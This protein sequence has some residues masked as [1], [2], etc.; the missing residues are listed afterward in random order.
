M[1]SYKLSSLTQACDLKKNIYVA[2]FIKLTKPFLYKT[3]LP[4]LLVM[5]GLYQNDEVSR[6][7][8]SPGIFGLS[9]RKT[10]EKFESN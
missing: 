2:V 7:N 10:S 8:F 3:S 5:L 1:F 9:G 6:S 4:S